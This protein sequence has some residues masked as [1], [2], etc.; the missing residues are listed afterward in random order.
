MAIE[1]PTVDDVRAIIGQSDLTDDQINSYIDD[2]ILI[3]ENCIKNLSPNRQKAIL[4]YV[5]AHLLYTTG[6]LDDTNSVA[7]TSRR[8]GDASETYARSELG[9]GLASSPYGQR[10]IELDPNRC[11]E[12]IGNQKRKAFV[13]VL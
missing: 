3:T 11:L 13:K 8:L 5:V 7:L 4:K 6:L 10:A 2:A 9:K 12:T 1:R